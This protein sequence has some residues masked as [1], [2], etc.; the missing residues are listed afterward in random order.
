MKR[1]LV[2]ASGFVALAILLFTL[3]L[4]LPLGGNPPFLGKFIEHRLELLRRMGGPEVRAPAEIPIPRRYIERTRAEVEAMMAT[5]DWAGLSREAKRQRLLAV[6]LVSGIDAEYWAMPEAR[7]RRV[8][9]AYV[10]AFL[11]PR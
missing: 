11:D 9:E 10:R 6:L 7:Q 8:A 1:N 5:P 2:V 3:G 4:L